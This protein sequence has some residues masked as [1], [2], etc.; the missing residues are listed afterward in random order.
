MKNRA[1]ELFQAAQAACVIG[2]LGK[3]EDIAAAVVFLAS[4]KS[5]FTVGQNLHVDGG[6]MQHIPF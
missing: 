3:P 1:P 4:P 5:G 2:R 6:Y